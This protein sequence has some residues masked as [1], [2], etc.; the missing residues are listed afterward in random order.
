M[1]SVKNIFSRLHGVLQ[2]KSVHHVFW[3]IFTQGMLSVV[4][5]LISI[6]LAVKTT[7]KE[8]GLYILLFSIISIF[9]NYHN[10]VI[11]T[12]LTILLRTQKCRNAF[13]SSFAFGQWI[14][15]APLIF[16]LITVA[17]SWSF[18][19]HEFTQL[20]IA[21]VLATGIAGYTWREFVRN[22]SYSLLKVGL[23]M[24]MD[25]IFIT[26]VLLSFGILIYT[27]IISSYIALLVLA[28]GYFVS[29]FFGH[30]NIGEHFTI[31]W[32]VIK[33][34]AIHSWKLSRWALVGVTS[35]ILQHSGYLYVLSLSLGLETVGDTSAA[36]LLMMPVG[37]LVQSSGRISLAKSAEILAKSGLKKLKNF[38]IALAGV[39]VTCCLAYVVILSV[40]YEMIAGILG[41]K[42]QSIKGYAFLWA[43]YFAA[44]CVRLP[45][46]NS[47]LACSQF[48]SVAIFDV[49]SGLATIIACIFLTGFFSGYGALLA[50]ASGEVLLCFLTIRMLILYRDDPSH[51]QM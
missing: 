20:K 13:I 10:A 30:Y 17:F 48:K 49:V 41:E 46:S 22:V 8:Y 36:K 29:A 15:I 45:L 40:F 44:N 14:L 7:K 43:L 3:S 12:P 25:F 19:H 34:T 35:S 4:S 18:F 28:A 50:V 9:G 27:K 33:S 47:L 2:K 26:V 42:Y 1:P 38:S 16:V 32:Q 11:N 21:A 37:F 51:V 6:I 23:V 24:K 5:F 39:F 31:D